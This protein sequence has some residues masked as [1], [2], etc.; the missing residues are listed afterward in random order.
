MYH[1][2]THPGPDPWGLR[3]TPAHLAGHFE[4]LQQRARSLRLRDLI[5]ALQRGAVPPQTVVVTF[6]D[7]YADN[8][9]NARPLMERYDIPAT[10]FLVSGNLASGDPFWWDEVER[11]FLYPGTL[12]TRLSLEIAGVVQEWDLGEASHYP[13]E[14]AILHN[15]WR[16]G[17]SAPSTRQSVYYS[18]WDML[19]PLAAGPRRAAIEQLVSWAGSRA[20]GRH[21]ARL[22][23][24]SEARSLGG[25]DLVE[26][27]AHSVTHPMLDTLPPARQQLEIE[28]SK[29]N[30]EEMIG[31]PVTSFAYPHGAHTAETAAL[32]RNAGYHCACSTV[33]AAVRPGTDPYRLPRMHV[34]DW[35]GEGFARRLSSWFEGTL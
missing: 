30:L 3:V 25:S 12:P 24:P 21:E 7:G 1:R 31:E 26:I 28:Q 4:V 13:E 29:A 34:E 22:L 18:V 14:V 11:V 5:P 32:V 8:L 23:S 10:F 17:Q 33:A 16:A 35:D 6:D 27:G 19:R 9:E 15:G 20:A 2:V